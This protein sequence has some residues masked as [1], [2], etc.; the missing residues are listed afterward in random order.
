M[1]N[2]ECERIMNDSGCD[3]LD[4]LVTAVFLSHT[5]ILTAIKKSGKKQKK[6]NLKIPKIDHFIHKCYIECAREFWRNP[7]LFSQK[8]SQAD[9]HRNIRES[10]KIISVTIEETIRKL[11]PVKN[12]LKEY[13]GEDGDSDPE[14]SFID[15]DYR[16]NLRKMVKKEIEICQGKDTEENNTPVEDII[17]EENLEKHEDIEDIKDVI[18]NNL[19][20]KDLS[21]E[22]NNDELSGVIDLDDIE[23]SMLVK[24]NKNNSTNN[25]EIKE[26]SVSETN[27]TKNAELESVETENVEL[28]PVETENAELE[29]VETENVELKSIET[30]NVEL[31]PVETETIETE[32]VELKPVETENVELKPVETENVETEN[33]ETENVETENV[34]TENVETENIETENNIQLDKTNN[35]EEKNSQVEEVKLEPV[36]E[37]NKKQDFDTTTT[38]FSNT[39]SELEKLNVQNNSLIDDFT[40]EE[41][42]VST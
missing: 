41:V 13:L 21:S 12:I 28:K 39:N 10:Q 18:S 2:T 30:E 38:S 4:E 42:D 7:Y 23:E 22:E 29:S 14:T 25:L 6:I 17:E 36:V 8:C 11:L 40:D 3:W 34:E 35:L 37:K 16:K 20:T 9:Y 1:L 27:E 33:V 31:K 15:K 24:S 5:K 19:Y 32:N 26:I